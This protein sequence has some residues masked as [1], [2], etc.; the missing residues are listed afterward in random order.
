MLGRRRR[1]AGGWVG[2]VLAGRQGVPAPVQGRGAR[3]GRRDAGR[4]GGREAGG[5]RA[6]AGRLGGAGRGRGR[7]LHRAATERALL[8]HA[9]AALERQ[10]R[11]LDVGL[12]VTSTRRARLGRRRPRED[13]VGRRHA[14]RQRHALRAVR[15]A[16]DAGRQHRGHGEPDATRGELCPVVERTTGRASPRRGGEPLP[17]HAGRALRDGPRA[18]G[19][20]RRGGGRTAGR[21]MCGA[22]PTRTTTGRRSRCGSR[23]RWGPQVGLTPPAHPRARDRGALRGAPPRARLHLRPT[24]VMSVVSTTIITR[25]E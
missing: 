3:G 17:A 6:G 2:A 18:R 1:G 23:S 19:G 22:R 13:R 15:D 12:T 21:W 24:G 10:A 5:R 16:A 14:R 7:G 25:A 9:V 11:A 8:G 4:A 20:P